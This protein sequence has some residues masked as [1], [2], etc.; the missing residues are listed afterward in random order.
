MNTFLSPYASAMIAPA[1]DQI[2][3]DFNISSLYLS[4]FTLSAFI[5]GYAG[6]SLVWSPLS[7]MFGRVKIIQASSLF[8]LAFNLGCG[9]STSA[10]QLIVLR[11]WSGFG[12]IGPIT[13]AAGVLG[14]LF[15]EEER[16]K[17]VALYSLLPLVAPAVSPIIGGFVCTRTTWRWQF[18]SSSIAGLMVFVASSVLLRETYNPPTSRRCSDS[19]P[20]GDDRSQ[21]RKGVRKMRIVFSALYTNLQRPAQLLLTQPIVIVLALYLSYLYGLLYIFITEFPTLWQERYH[22][23]LS[24]SGLHYVSLGLGLLLGAIPSFL[25]NDKVFQCLKKRN[26]GP[27]KPE[28]RLPLMLPAS[29]LVPTGLLV[30][31]WSAQARVHWIVPD[32]GTAIFAAGAWSGYQCIQAYAI[33]YYTTYAASAMAAL[34]F[35]RCVV[36]TFLPLLA[37]ALYQN[38]GYGWGNT[39]LAGIA[40]VFGVPAPLLL[41]IYGEKLRTKSKYSERLV[42]DVVC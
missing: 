39:L 37:P 36:G 10:T 28:Y 14:D 7:E 25:A 31:G 21:V 2:S 4:Q 1:L 23:R 30:Y 34:T 5:L 40:V 15:S 12:G 38:F 11:F 16:G 19:K 32:I 42:N 3:T 6:G 22:Q 35:V 29:I 18:W 24:I 27:G 9:F 33:D 26:S 41:W 13:V 17:S 20:D 8:F